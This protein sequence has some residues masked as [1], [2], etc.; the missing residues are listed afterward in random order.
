M[1][2]LKPILASRTVWSNLIGLAALALPAFGI[3]ATALGDQSAL[4]D[5]ALQTLGGGAFIA[6]TVFRVIATKRLL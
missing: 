1:N 2:S 4:L 5:A 6:S 3:P